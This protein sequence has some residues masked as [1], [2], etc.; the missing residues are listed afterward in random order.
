MKLTLE[1]DY[2]QGALEKL[3]EEQDRTKMIMKCVFDLL[4]RSKSLFDEQELKMN[5]NIT[6]SA[7]INSDQEQ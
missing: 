3:L 1:I 4:L 7:I 2:T 5:D 6:V